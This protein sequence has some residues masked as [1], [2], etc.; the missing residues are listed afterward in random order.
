MSDDLR[1][2]LG[3]MRDG[4]SDE[5]G[6]I[7]LPA[8]R[9]IHS[10]ER[11]DDLVRRLDEPAIGNALQSIAHGGITV[12]ACHDPRQCLIETCRTRGRRDRSSRRQAVT[13]HRKVAGRN[14]RC[15]RRRKPRS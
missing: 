13:C 14:A 8:A 1:E 10:I 11:S 15:A 9:R 6:Q 7:L 12:R 5:R 3:L 2:E 4:G